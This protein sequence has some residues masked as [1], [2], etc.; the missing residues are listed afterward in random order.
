M[1]SALRTN[2]R[3]MRSAPSLQ[4]PAEVG[5]VLLRQ[6]GHVDRDAGQVDAL[7]VR[8]RRRRRSTSVVTTVPSV[9]MTSTLHLA[10]V[11]QQESPGLHVLR[12]A[13]EG[14]ARTISLVPTMSSVV[15]VKM[16]PTAR[17][18]G[19]SSNLP[20]RIFGPCR[21][22]STATG[23]TGVVGGLAHVRED[24]LVHGVVA[25]AE[26]HAG[27]VDARV[28][29]RPDVLV[30]RGGGS[31]GGDDLCASHRVPSRW[32]G[33]EVPQA[34]LRGSSRPIATS[35]GR[36]GNGQLRLPFKVPVDVRKPQH[37][38]RRSPRR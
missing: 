31:E 36:T 5:L 24:L 30:A 32:F 14:R 33:G 17:S 25:V 38:P 4:A 29:D 35:V 12:Q 11:D 10:V 8:H 22:T 2:D 3:A 15:I 34:S 21:S 16:S 6:R 37:G 27:D 9:S 7:V 23:A 13:L 1:S 26:V 19:P 18:C 20:R 28:D